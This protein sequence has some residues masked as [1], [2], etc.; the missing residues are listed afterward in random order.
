MSSITAG[1]VTVGSLNFRTYSGFRK[2]CVMNLYL[3]PGYIKHDVTAIGWYGRRTEYE[4]VAIDSTVSDFFMS[5]PIWKKASFYNVNNFSGVFFIICSEV[6]QVGVE[7]HVCFFGRAT[8]DSGG[9]ERG[10]V[11]FHQLGVHVSTFVI[12][13][14]AGRIFAQVVNGFSFFV[15]EYP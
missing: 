6:C 4:E 2:K 8:V 11:A 10:A 1:I 14:N 13:E 9:G 3:S 12:H 5:N 7:G 15:F